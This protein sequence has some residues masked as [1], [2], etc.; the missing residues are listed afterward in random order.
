[1]C[2]IVGLLNFGTA[3]AD[4]LGILCKMRDA[5]RHR[6]P[7]AAGVYQSPDRRVVLGHRRLSIVDLSEAGKQP[8][9]NEDQTVWITFNGEV[10]N[11]QELRNDLNGHTFRSRTDTEAIIHLYEQF[12]SDAIS[13]LD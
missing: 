9:T 6:G 13:K 2:G 10:Y 3:V 5:M 1:M 11:H 12:G 4:E 8:M 7:D